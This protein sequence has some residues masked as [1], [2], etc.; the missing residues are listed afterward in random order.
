MGLINRGKGGW[1]N[2]AGLE[3][4][5]IKSKQADPK[6]GPEAEV[7]KLEELVARMEKVKQKAEARKDEKGA[8]DAAKK[9]DELKLVIAELTPKKTIEEAVQA[10]DA[11]KL[12]SVIKATY[13]RTLSRLPS[14]TELTRSIAYVDSTDNKLRGVSDIL[15]ALINTKEFIVNH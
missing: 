6:R 5:L 1:I 3:L 4:G 10:T 7:R 9:V 15:W 11:D 14:E 12:A 8:A 13:L 2:Q